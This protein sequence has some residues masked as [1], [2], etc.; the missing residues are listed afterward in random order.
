MIV[1][2]RR[3]P[4]RARSLVDWVAL[5]LDACTRSADGVASP[6]VVIWCDPDQQWL[7]LLPRLRES[8]QQL[9]CLGDYGPAARTGPAIWLRCIVDRTIPDATHPADVAPI[10]YLPGIARQGLRG[11]SDQSE[12]TLPLVELQYRG[13]SFHQAN[14]RDW[15]VEAALRANQLDV[16][17]DLRTREAMLRSLAVLG[18]VELDTLRLGRLDEGDFDRLSVQDPV[19]D[20][21]R[22]LNDPESLRR[23]TSPQA[24]KAFANV[25][26]SQFGI[27]PERDATS[28]AA[29]LM[30]RS[31]PRWET[32][33]ERFCY[34]PSVHP[35]LRNLL[36]NP[37]SV[38]GELLVDASR[39]APAN[40]E[41]EERLRDA[42]EQVSQFPHHQ[43]CARI[44][45][46]EKEHGL[47]RGWV[48]TQLYESPYAVALAPL[49]RLADRA[50]TI[51]TATTLEGAIA[52]YASEGHLCDT[53]A[54]EALSSATN[55]RMR[56][57]IGGV[58]RA[59][60]LPWLD[61][62]ARTFQALF[63]HS[64]DSSS[65]PQ[66]TTAE[67]DVCILFADGLR[68]DVGRSLAE[69]LRG[70]GCEVALTPRLA[71]TPTATPSA[72]PAVTPVASVIA[73]PNEAEDFVPVFT[74]SGKVADALRQRSEMER[75]GIAFLPEDEKSGPSSLNGGWTEYG[76][77][78]YLGHN[79]GLDLARELDRQVEG[80]EERV[81]ALL[82]A[83]WLAVRVVTDHGW[84][85]VPGGL[86]KVE[87]P[88]HLTQ[89]KWARCAVVRGESQV[90]VPT[91]PWS[92]NSDVRIA[93]PP[94]AGSFIANTV[95]AHGGVSPQE[96]ITPEL[97][98]TLGEKPQRQ[99]C[100]SDV[101]WSRL[102]CRV[103][104][105]NATA[106]GGLLV[107]LRTR[108]KDPAKSV[109]AA[110]KAVDALGEVSLVVADEDLEGT[111]VQVVLMGS[112]GTVIDKRP[113]TVG[114]AT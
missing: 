17:Q 60:Y 49:A 28:D 86:P 78:D 81:M 91:F 67:K 9:Y 1:V 40:K 12:A 63:G 62:H 37:L 111:A 106:D 50:E 13:A 11:G 73:G 107:D 61:A 100:I 47:R 88:A 59:L 16:A 83:G 113:T 4:T 76:K 90:S 74:E 8:I 65:K 51:D 75:R 31:D 34:A 66:G 33:W 20:I 79:I 46:L 5:S 6:V 23:G 54:M 56:D 71:A 99:A 19:R 110:P 95:Y 18:D 44:A 26:R 3:T 103:S 14:G 45:E 69:Q 32:V 29:A 52:D 98:V 24:W 105:T 57:V 68:F 64:T 42:L 38:Q 36:H 96:C 22:W 82:G 35:G 97:V 93:S 87:V 109:A 53:A 92:W 72:R 84:L 114:E 85:L 112:D 43:A 70:R 89:S 39:N 94:G 41:A 10:L 30:V 25:A 15:T 58:V 48:W 104:V 27:D 102:R 21:L 77:I 55:A 101:R 2:S 80:L 7:P 108:W